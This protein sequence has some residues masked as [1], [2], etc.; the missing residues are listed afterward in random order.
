MKQT[1]TAKLKLQ[2]TPEQFAALRTTQLAYR[3]ALNFVSRYSFEHGK[4]SSHA[5][6]QKGTYSDVRAQFHLPAQLTCSVMREVAATYKGHWTKAK[7][8]A[9]ARKAGQTTRRYK[10]LDTPPKFVSPT[11]TYQRGKDYGFK[12][13]QQVSM[14]T[15][16]GR[17]VVSYQG[18]HKHITLLQ[19]GAEVG[20]AKLWYDKAHRQYYLLGSF[21]VE[22]PDPTPEQN[23]QVIGVDVGVRYLAV[24]SPYTGDPTFHSGKQIRNRA[25]HYARV[26]KRLQ[27]KGT[28]SATRRLVALSGRERRLKANANHTISRRI[29]TDHPHALIGIEELTGIRE[30]TRRRAHRRKK[31]GKGVERASVRQRKSN[32]VYSQ[33]SFAELHGMLAYKAVLSGSVVV[34]VDA[35]YTSKGCPIC[36]HIDEANRLNHGLLFCCVNCHY[37]LH[38]DLIGARNIVMRTLLVRQDWARTG[39]LSIAPG[40]SA[41]EPDVSVGE[42]KAAR[43]KRYAELR[44]RPETSSWS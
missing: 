10:G 37:S 30:R 7:K 24:T 16:D 42:A 28:R 38:T 19:R 20:A 21:E 40:S 18:Y 15:L 39:Q 35:D 34:R 23:T 26:R 44:W 32:R 8:N 14:L 6:L 9:A 12:A 31:N 11:L 3:D 27:K 36:G 33:W 17:V 43:L 25:N 29:V 22:R 41:E 4:I 1:L 2:T 5:G 13:N